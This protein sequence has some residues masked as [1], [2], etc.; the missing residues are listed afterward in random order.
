[1]ERA[2]R[3]V[4]PLWV[5]PTTSGAG[6]IAA[7]LGLL[8]LPTPERWAQLAWPG[9]SDSAS[10]LVQTVAGSVI[11]VTT[12]TFTLTVVALQL[13]SQQFSPRLLREFTRDRATK[14]VLSVLVGSFVL[15][16]TVLRGLRADTPVPAL[17]VHRLRGSARVARGDSCASSRISC[18]DF[19]STR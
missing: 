11:T 19:G 4:P 6:A 13:A 17:A 2:Q 7:A 16:V 3:R 18:R 12:L 10:A 1:M 9:D 15:S 14:I 5:W 8:R